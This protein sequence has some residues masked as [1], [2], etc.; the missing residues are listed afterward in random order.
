MASKSVYIQKNKLVI[1]G[2]KSLKVEPPIMGQ[3]IERA[4]KVF[5]ALAKSKIRT[6]TGNL[7]ESIG[8]IERDKSG[9]GKALRMIGARVYGPYKGHHAHLIEE[10]TADRSK[11]RK[12]NVTASGEKYAPNIGPAKPFMKPAFEQGKTI[13]TQII[14]K[15]A[16]DYLADKAKKAGLK[17]K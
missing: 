8:F 11:E 13:Y 7:R 15:L 10:G 9:Y 1:D 4:G 5:I 12:R 17:T 2:L 3:F 6:K 16:T 14:T